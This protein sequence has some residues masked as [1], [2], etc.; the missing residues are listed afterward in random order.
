MIETWVDVLRQ[1]F[2]DIW[3]GV[4]D[5]IPYLIGAVIIFIVGWVVGS[6]LGQVVAQ[7]I[8]VLPV[9]TALRHA[10]VEEVLKRAGFNL[11]SGKFLGALVKWFVIIV[12]LVASLDVLGLQQ[13]NLFL[14]KVLLYLPDVIVAVFILLA[15]ALIGEAMQRLVVGTSQAAGITAANFLGTVTRWSIWIFAILMALFQLGIAAPFMTALFQGIVVAIAL[16]FGLSFGLGGQ[17][18]AAKFLERVRS[19]IRHTR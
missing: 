16:A 14:E 9:D 8:K 3:M 15:A 2:Q 4:A 1:S 13:V 7:I 17:D 12:F 6:L 5:F 10:R 19:E 18:A 11:D